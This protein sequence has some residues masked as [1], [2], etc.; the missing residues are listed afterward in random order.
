MFP[1]RFTVLNGDYSTPI[2]PRA[3]RVMVNIQRSNMLEQILCARAD[4]G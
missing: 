2:I 1:L 3:V 4:P